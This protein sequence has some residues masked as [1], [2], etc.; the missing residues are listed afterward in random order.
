MFVIN[1]EKRAKCGKILKEMFI[2]FRTMTYKILK[3]LNFHIYYFWF[4]SM[5]FIC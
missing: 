1:R 3:T 4:N 5:Y 2:F